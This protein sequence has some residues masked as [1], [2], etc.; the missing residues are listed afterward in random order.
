MSIAELYLLLVSS[1]IHLVAFLSFQ[2][3]VAFKSTEVLRDLPTPPIPDLGQNNVHNQVTQPQEMIMPAQVVPQIPTS[4][5]SS[6]GADVDDFDDF[7]QAPSH[8]N[9]MIR[10]NVDVQNEC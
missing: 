7:Q 6:A 4:A 3:E 8:T 5:P 1:I 9:G 2:N 10:L